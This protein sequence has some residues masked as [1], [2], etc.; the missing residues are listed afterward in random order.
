[1]LAP[2]RKR[3]GMPVRVRGI[4]EELDCVEEGAAADSDNEVNGIEVFIAAEAASEI[5]FRINGGI[6][7]VAERAKEPQERVAIFVG[8]LK[9]QADQVGDWDLVPK[10]A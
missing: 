2:V 9:A 10:C 6:K 4:F 1:M 7:F 3:G 5:G 8:E